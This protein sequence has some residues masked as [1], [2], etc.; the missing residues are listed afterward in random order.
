MPGRHHAVQFTDPSGGANVAYVGTRATGS[1]PG[2]YV[3]GVPD[4][5]GR[6]PAGVERNAVPHGSALVI[7]RVLVAN[8][9]DKSA[10]LELARQIWLAP[11]EHR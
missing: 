4:R 1:G 6:V 2:R 8:D 11:L 10:A 3:L 9:A 7:G 5:E